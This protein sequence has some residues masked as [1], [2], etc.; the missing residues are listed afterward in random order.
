MIKIFYRHRK[1]HRVL[2]AVSSLGLL[3]FG[4]TV[5]LLWIL[6]MPLFIKMVVYVA[7][8]YYLF[9][10]FNALMEL[11]SFDNFTFHIRQ[12][13]L[14]ISFGIIEL[15]LLIYFQNKNINTFLFLAGGYTGIYFTICLVN[16]VLGIYQ[17]QSNHILKVKTFFKFE[18]LTILCI[19]ILLTVL[20]V[21]SWIIFSI[22]IISLGIF[23]SLAELIISHLSEK[24]GRNE[25]GYMINYA[26]KNRKSK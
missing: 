13:V 14:F 15:I 8:L 7:T 16:D 19:A 17:F 23:Y 6:N 26:E 12:K 3:I 24:R 2:E 4:F 21:V 5:L 11:Q 18:L 10:I 1:T 25:M 22:V 20:S 9:Q